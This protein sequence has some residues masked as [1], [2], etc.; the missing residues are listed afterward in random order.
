MKEL[1]A[2]FQKQTGSN[3]ATDFTNSSYEKWLET[4]LIQYQKKENYYK[5]EFLKEVAN[6]LHSAEKKHPKYPKCDF[7]KL[8]I[9]SEEAGEVAKAVLH[10]HYENGSLEDIKTELTQTA[11]MCMRMYNSLL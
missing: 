5:R 3:I 11:A 7:K 8:A 10:Y 6:E 2:K 4:E 1:K 9:L